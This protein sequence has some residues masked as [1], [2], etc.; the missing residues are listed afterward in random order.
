MTREGKPQSSTQ[1]IPLATGGGASD[2][3]LFANEAEYFIHTRGLDGSRRIVTVLDTFSLGEGADFP[4]DP[5]APQIV[6]AAESITL[7]GTFAA[8]GIALSSNHISSR[9][10]AA[11][12]VSGAATR[13]YP[14]PAASGDGS[15]GA[16]G[17]PAG[18]ITLFTEVLPS[19][20]EGAIALPR[21]LAR[22][23]P[24]QDGQDAIHG[25]GGD[26]GRGGSGGSVAAYVSSPYL[27]AVDALDALLSNLDSR[28]KVNAMAVT[29][30]AFDPKT[31]LPNGST[32]EDA[33]ATLLKLGAQLFPDKDNPAAPVEDGGRI[34]AQLAQ[35]ASTIINGLQSRS[36][37]LRTS[38]L[39]SLLVS[40]GDP[41][42]GGTGRAR[43]GEADANGPVP[44]SGAATLA[45]YGDTS[46]LNPQ[47]PADEQV[48]LIVRLIDVTQ[49]QM[50]LQKA[51]MRYLQADA[52]SNPD[53]LTDTAKLFQRLVNRLAFVP[54]WLGAD[55]KMP[56][57]RLD[58]YHRIYREASSYLA[59]FSKGLDY[60][61]YGVNAVPLVDLGVC[62]NALPDLLSSFQSIE[63]RY[64]AYFKALQTQAETRDQITAARGDATAALG[65]AALNI[66]DLKTRLDAVGGTILQYEAP[67]ARKKQHLESILQN[68]VDDIKSYYNFS[69]ASGFGLFKD[70]V[71]ALSSVA[72]MPESGFMSGVQ[73]VSAVGD[74]INS[75][76]VQPTTTITNDSG[77]TIDKTYLVNQVSAVKD[78]VGGLSEGYKA[79]DDG[80]LQPD[81]PGA[82]KLLMTESQ[83][84]RILDDFRSELPDD[85]QAVQK[86]FQD[87]IDTIVARNNAIMD[88]NAIVNVIGACL[89]QQQSAQEAL[90]QLSGD[91]F[92]ELDPGLPSM[93]TMLSQ[94][95]HQSRDQLMNACYIASRALQFWSLSNTNFLA[96]ALAVDAGGVQPSAITYSFWESKLDAEHLNA[97]QQFGTN[98]SHFPNHDSED[99]AIIAFTDDATLT[100][101]RTAYGVTL[102]VPLIR[103]P[104]TPGRT[105]S[106]LD[107]AW[108]NQL[109]VDQ[110]NV[111]LLDVRVWL[112]GAKIVKDGIEVDDVIH[113]RVTHGGYS[114][115][116]SQS[117][118]VFRFTHG[119]VP[120]T[121]QYYTRSRDPQ[122]PHRPE[123][124]RTANFGD[125]TQDDPT[126]GKN[127]ALL[128]PFT[129][130]TI[131]LMNTVES[132]T[133]L[134]LLDAL[135]QGVVERG[136]IINYDGHSQV[137]SAVE[138][139]DDGAVAIDVALY[140]V[141]I[142]TFTVKGTT[143]TDRSGAVVPAP[144]IILQGQ[145]STYIDLTGLTAI[146]L[147]F[148]GTSY[149]FA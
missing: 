83:L 34:V 12:D 74:L 27:A 137:V 22:G 138:T 8:S 136:V 23:G 82:A 122:A 101:F 96:Q 117:N 38:L 48:G 120:K 134:G 43:D 24:G 68:V 71:G 88:Y 130:W 58:A 133:T 25:G 143:I 86:A 85:I 9:S 21:L 16:P 97:L 39:P 17:K 106:R 132:P 14:L 60:Y 41:G 1:Y 149:T 65:Q 92:D 50:L 135:K 116:A 78:T 121:F 93:V 84:E 100:T 141:T 47:A 51:K 42:R 56:D 13:P 63:A 54:A 66:A 95:Y 105:P 64:A 3:L 2:A 44:S 118:D 87:Y 53:A 77:V 113:V 145:S 127:Y 67:V 61:G 80:Q 90:D 4:G 45:L 102:R 59:N 55:G 46:S 49:C 18:T 33:V 29:L 147:E 107:A 81:D 131:E 35:I 76:V 30:R 40:A 15:P 112:D 28:N 119:S 110:A 128:S 139:G 125:V 70:L 73:G 20:A 104:D 146:R 10:G 94:L 115:F 31:L 98:P 126:Q 72:F 91:S 75:V 140:G 32:L 19:D 144:V 111:R 89:S 142:Q 52:V 123:I 6:V 57:P 124:L 37:T 62:L 5:G 99:G 103:R 148:T 69:F 11:L 26:G 108:Q 109:L 36:D 79:L 114:L 7:S 129:D